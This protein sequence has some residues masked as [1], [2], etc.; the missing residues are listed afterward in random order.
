MGTI[1]GPY[2]R[3]MPRLGRPLLAGLRALLLHG[4][5]MC[6]GSAVAIPQVASGPAAS[7]V[8]AAAVE[9]MP[10]V[11]E[12]EPSAAV[13][14]LNNREIVTFRA[15]LLGATP[16]RRVER[17]QA[18]LELALG[19]SESAQIRRSEAGQA[20][21][22]ELN[23]ITLFFLSIDDMADSQPG[24]GIEP[25]A[26]EVERRLATAVRERHEATE[27]RKLALGAAFSAGASLLAWV[28]LRA[29]AA[30]RRHAMVGLDAQ[31]EDWRQRH[32]GKAFLSTYADHLR[33]G[34]RRSADAVY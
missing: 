14:R 23:G 2:R 3:R 17:A 15:R 9:A 19:V 28:L 12:A 8:S 32:Q 29:L 6:A 26:L 4:G 16:Q 5:L 24:L 20:Q 30:L 13:L 7:S 25:A 11:V 21:R 10:T 31:I 1:D 33:A 34:A 18:A 27:P 22:F